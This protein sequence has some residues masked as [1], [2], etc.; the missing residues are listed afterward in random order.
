MYLNEIGFD[1]QSWF[2]NTYNI[3]HPLSNKVDSVRFVQELLNIDSNDVITVGDSFYDLEMIK[4]Y[5]SYG[6]VKLFP[7]L[8]ILRNC[9]KKVK[10]LGSA[11][12]DI[13]KNI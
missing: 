5:Y 11:F 9:N 8:D 2:L 4:S 6:I 12:K 10:S 3:V 13:N 1:V 7:N